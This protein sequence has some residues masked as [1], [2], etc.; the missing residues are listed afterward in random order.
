M[1][2]DSPDAVT[3][4]DTT[5]PF[6][7]PSKVAP[8]HTLRALIASV[9]VLIVLACALFL[10]YLRGEALRGAEEKAASGARLLEEPV[11][12]TFRTADFIVE[13]VAML[14]RSQPMEHL[15]N[16]ESAWMR[17]TELKRGMPE[18]GT[19][20]IIDAKGRSVLGTLTFPVRAASVADRH[21]F[22]A[23]LEK[24]RDLV[25]GPLVN[26]KQRDAQAFHLSRRIDDDQGTLLGVAVVGFDAITFTDFYR[27]LG[28]TPHSVLTVSGLDG[29]IVLRQPD[30][31]QWAET[32]MPAQGPLMQ[33][34]QAGRTRGILRTVSPLDG[35]ERMLAFRV[36]P[37]FGM[38]VSAGVALDDVLSNWWDT[39]LLTVTAVLMLMGLL[40]WLAAMAFDSLKRE[41]ELIQGLEETVRERTREAEQRAEEARRANDSKTRFLAAASHDLRQPLQAAGMFV[42]ALA[43]RLGGSPHQAIVD[44]M[45]QSVDATQALLSTLLDVS[46]LEAGHI[47]PAPT[48]FALAPMMTALVEQLEPEATKRGLEL[49]LVPT[50]AVVIS[51]PVLL[52]RMLRNLLYNALRYTKDGKILLGC[53]RRPGRVAICVDHTGFGIPVYMFATICE[54][55]TRLGPM[56]PRADRGLGLGLAVVR[57]MAEQL[58]HDIEV[59]SRVDKGSSFA[60]VVPTL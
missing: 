49:R 11:N 45:R 53:R 30:P 40:G 60:V 1:L 16:S 8:R 57:R 10:A 52:E 5:A 48:S 59:R 3:D 28:L 47:E 39:A 50:K 54:D 41:E 25:I 44:K 42:E 7:P 2:Q 33:A 29:R 34:V 19:L 15:A 46:T 27:N 37:E 13:Q 55:F 51:D 58:D 20:W 6:P 56:G 14:G 9:T 21:Y 12:R 32:Y 38:V 4:T 26:T 23:H 35:V 24:R 31:E 18:P 17:L 36:L 43:A 22:S